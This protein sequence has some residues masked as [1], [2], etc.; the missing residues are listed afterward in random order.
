MN[1]ILVY[2][3]A[4]RKARDAAD[5]TKSLHLSIKRGKVISNIALRALHR[6][7]AKC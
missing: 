2:G 5:I 7:D 6:R 1:S 4:H 3:P